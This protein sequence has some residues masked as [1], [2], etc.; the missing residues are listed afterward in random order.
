MQNHSIQQY[1][2]EQGFADGCLK[3]SENKMTHSSPLDVL[4]QYLAHTVDWWAIT[5][6]GTSSCINPVEIWTI[7]VG[8]SSHEKSAPFFGFHLEIRR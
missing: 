3:G 8:P 4:R 7:I 6:R 5:G 1:L 2:V